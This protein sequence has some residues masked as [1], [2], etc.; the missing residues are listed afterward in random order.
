MQATH[1]NYNLKPMESE[2]R[3]VLAEECR[4]DLE[5]PL[6]L[7]LSGGPD[8]TALL[9]VLQRLNYQL[10][11]AHFDH[12][13]RPDSGDQAIQ[14]K[15]ILKV[16][17]YHLVFGSGDVIQFSLDNHQSIEEAARNLRYGFLFETAREYHAQAV[18]VGHTSDDQVETILMHLLR[19][20]GA[21]GMKGMT[22]NSLPNAWSDRI[23]LIR[24]LL[25]VWRA[26]IAAYVK[27]RQLPTLLDESNQDPRFLRNRLRLELVPLLERLN[28]GAR[29]HIWQTSSIL[30][31]E[32]SI[33]DQIIE[34]AWETTCRIQQQEAIG[35]D[36]RLL[37][38]QPKAVQ[39]RLLRKAV[40][41]INQDLSEVGFE[42]NRK[43]D[44]ISKLAE[45][46][47]ED[48]A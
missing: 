12:R 43:G 1:L 2:V 19:G 15:Q 6:V 21:E 47:A 48:C 11:I 37:K 33:V 36:T 24:P 34:K 30:E 26:E 40:K 46:P 35:F 8:S 13:L 5:K 25:G 17:G 16:R 32:D 38:A 27:E 3:R 22:Y 14:L 28:P 9:E 7:G 18:A 44:P 41:S 39:R 10:V 45:P 29:R 42:F 20:S 4:V 23:A 31:A